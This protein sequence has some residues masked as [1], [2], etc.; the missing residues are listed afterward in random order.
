MFV[1]KNS[2]KVVKFDKK[3]IIRTCMRAG[4]SRKHAKNI[5]DEVEKKIYDRIPTK[6][7]LK[8]ILS[9]IRKIDRFASMKYDLKGSIMKLGPSGFTFERFISKLL[10]SQGYKTKINVVINGRCAKHEVDIIAEKN[11]QSIIECKYH[12]YPG[13]YTG[14]KDA[15]YTYARFVDIKEV[16]RNKEFKDVWLVSNTKFSSDAVKYSTCR[17]ITLVG[18][19]Y[20][21]GKSLTDLIENKKMYPVTILKSISKS[22]LLKLL[23]YNIITIKDLIDQKPDIKGISNI[24]KE[25]ER[26]TEK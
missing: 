10:E 21:K 1:T 25:A 15:L 3:R 23:K 6:I 19:K 7:I 8:I 17:G 9:E 13:I 16:S 24:L 2:G 11:G 5:A 20:P 12:N 18:W 4:L 22:T 26:L 14:I